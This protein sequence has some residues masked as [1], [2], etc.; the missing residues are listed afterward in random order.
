MGGVHDIC[1][2]IW[3]IARSV[4]MRAISY[5][6]QRRNCIST[7]DVIYDVISYRAIRGLVSVERGGTLF[8]ASHEFVKSF[9]RQHIANRISSLPFFKASF[10]LIFSR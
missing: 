1:L 6:S 2:G 3:M 7:A 8:Q 4:A 10:F 5:S 9:S